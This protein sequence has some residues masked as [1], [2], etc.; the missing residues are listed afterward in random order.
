MKDLVTMLCGRNWR[1]VTQ[2]LAMARS[3]H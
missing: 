1:T 2:L 3:A